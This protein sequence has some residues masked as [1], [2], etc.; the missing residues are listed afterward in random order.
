MTKRLT[1]AALAFLAMAGHANAE[2]IKIGVVAT[3]E[4]AFTALGEDGVRG[5]LMAVAEFGDTLG[6]TIVLTTASSD[7]TP[8]SAVAATRKLVENDGLRFVVGP[9][10]GDEGRAVKDYAKSQPGT[11]FVNGTSAAQDTTL[12]EPAS[13]FFRFSTDGAQWM[14]GLGSYSHDTKGYKSVAVVAEDY[15]FPYTQVFGFMHEFCAVGGHVPEKFW[16]PIGQK[17][18]SSVVASIPD[19]ID[20]IF[21]GL[22]GADAVNFLTQYAQAGGDKPIIASTFTADQTILSSKGRFKDYLIGTPSAGPTADSWNGPEWQAFVAAYQKQFPDGFP[23]P[24]LAAYTYYVNTKALLLAL[25]EAGGD[26]GQDHERLNAILSKISFTSPMGGTI[27][28]D[29]NRQAISDN[30]VTEVAEDADGHLYN[31]VVAQAEQIDQTLGMSRDAFLAL[32]PVS[33]D[34]PSC[35]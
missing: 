30:F 8:A 20:G 14:A 33:R 29:D 25:K 21:V 4:G 32:G 19:G 34:N 24:S 35:P 18:Y 2:D 1:T 16:V 9:L 28:L 22:S 12:R 17:D 31:K 11:T 3:L 13:N 7:A 6:E 10:S 5:V 23:G 26:L 27:R 15:S